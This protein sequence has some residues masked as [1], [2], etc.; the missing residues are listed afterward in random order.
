MELQK[1]IRMTESPK[2][3]KIKTVIVDINIYGNVQ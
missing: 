3:N 2:D 1:G